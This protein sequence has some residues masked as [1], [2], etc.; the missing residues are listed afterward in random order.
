MNVVLPDPLPPVIPIISGFMC[1]YYGAK[2][3]I[4][5]PSKNIQRDILLKIFSNYLYSTDCTG[6]KESEKE[7]VV[8]TP[9][10]DVTEIEPP[11]RSTTFLQMASP[12]PA[13][14]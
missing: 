10:C 8:P 13:P 2:I 5:F 12:I 9:A 3:K 6:K 1:Q 7:N 11:W 14:W 4:F